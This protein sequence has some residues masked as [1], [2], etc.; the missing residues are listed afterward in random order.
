MGDFIDGSNNTANPY[1]QLLSVTNDTAKAHQDFVQV[2]LG[3]NGTT[4][5]E[6]ALGKSSSHKPSLSSMK[7]KPLSKGAKIAVAAAIAGLL[8]LALF[9]G[10]I[11]CCCCRNR[12]KR[13]SKNTAY[14]N[15]SYQ[16]LLVPAPDAATE[17]HTAYNPQYAPQGASYNPQPYTPYDPPPPLQGGYQTPYDKRY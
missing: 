7:K 10:L 1:L 12:G 15:S 13:S 6:S 4:N 5:D 17:M 8:I 2:R 9:V 11:W 3:G 14:P 16:P